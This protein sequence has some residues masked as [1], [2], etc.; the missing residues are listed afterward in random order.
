[1][2][3]RFRLTWVK[4][5]SYDPARGQNIVSLLDSSMASHFPKV[6]AFL[7]YDILSGNLSLPCP[8]FGHL[9]L[10]YLVIP[11]SPATPVWIHHLLPSMPFNHYL[12]SRF[13][14]WNF[15]P[16]WLLP[17]DHASL[18]AIR[19]MDSSDWM[20][21]SSCL[22]EVQAFFGRKLIWPSKLKH[23]CYIPASLQGIPV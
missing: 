17:A 1:M 14:L 4:M 18:G 16:G 9:P 8:W 12:T 13:H 11:I 3:R 19:S 15:W 10:T 6:S 23:R 7:V 2:Q 5:D 20:A 21:L 22:R